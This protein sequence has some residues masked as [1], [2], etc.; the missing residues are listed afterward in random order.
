MKRLIAAALSLSLCVPA[1]LAAESPA[2]SDV[3]ADAW[4]SSGVEVCTGAGL[5]NGT[6]EDLF[7]PGKELSKPEC[8]VL[9]LRIHN[10]THGGDGTFAPA[11]ADWGKITLTAGGETFSGYPAE[12]S[13]WTWSQQGAAH[14]FFLGVALDTPERRTWAATADSQPAALS[15][16]GLTFPGAMHKAGTQLYFQPDDF[17][18]AY[19]EAVASRVDRPGPGVWYRDAWYYAW[20]NQLSSLLGSENTPEFRLGFAQNIAAVADLT[21][22]NQIDALP[23][24]AQADVLALYNAGI[25]TGSDACG[26]FNEYA[27]LTRAEAAVICARVLRPEL[28]KALTLE[29]PATYENY[30]LT[31]LRDDADRPNGPYRPLQSEALLA[32]GD[33]TLLR[34][35]GTSLPLPAGYEVAGI[36][37]DKAGLR[38]PDGSLFGIIDSQGT[39]QA[40]TMDEAYAIYSTFNSETPYHGYLFGGCYRSA[41]GDQVTETF[42]WCGPLNADGRGFVG[43]GGKIYRIELG[44]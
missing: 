40:A 27:H 21:P 34:L 38:T 26:T 2:F 44:G 28:R 13:I 31:Y 15:M 25:L 6:G 42:Q 8:S 19:Q 20:T 39:F 32:P 33:G 12:E 18:Q 37:Q 14:S 30:T 24:T 7:S 41:D 43:K 36:E 23:D 9:A 5:M 3:P 29:R 4:Y 1:A 22:I 16:D 17:S 10:L 11:P 35:D